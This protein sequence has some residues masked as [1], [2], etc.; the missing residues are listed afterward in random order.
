MATIGTILIQAANQA[1]GITGG[2]APSIAGMGGGTSSDDLKEQKRLTEYA[3]KNE[4]NNKQTPKFWT[5]AFKKMG[6]QMGLAGIL[7]QSQIFTSSVGAIFQIFG[8]FV[9]VILAPFVPM[10]I[11]AIRWLARQLKAAQATADGLS[12]VVKAVWN[13]FFGG[14]FKEN[15]KSLFTGLKDGIV[16]GVTGAFSGLINVVDNLWSHVE[17]FLS[18]VWEK[19]R[20]GLKKAWNSTLGGVRVPYIGWTIPTWGGGGGGTTTKTTTMPGS[21]NS[22]MG[23][24][25]STVTYDKDG[26]LIA[27]EDLTTIEGRFTPNPKVKAWL[28]TMGTEGP[29]IKSN[30]GDLDK[31]GREITGNGPDGADGSWWNKIFSKDTWSGAFGDLTTE[32]KKFFSGGLIQ[33]VLTAVGITVGGSVGVA[34]LGKGIGAFGNVMKAAMWSPKQLVNLLNAAAKTPGMMG[35]NT[36]K[37]AVRQLNLSKGAPSVVGTLR[38]LGLTEGATDLARRA[39]K[40][41][42]GGVGNATLEAW[43]RVTQPVADARRIASGA[44]NRVLRRTPVPMVPTVD[45]PNPRVPRISPNYTAGGDLA[46]QPGGRNPLPQGRGTSTVFSDDLAQAKGPSKLSRAVQA[47]NRWITKTGG[48]LKN[49]AGAGANAFKSVFDEGFS[50]ADDVVRIAAKTPGMGSIGQMVSFGFKRVIPGIAGAYMVGET[51]QDVWK[52]VKSD[53]PWLGDWKSLS[54]YKAEAMGAI[55]STSG[56]TGFGN[57]VGLLTGLFGKAQSAL[58]LGDSISEWQANIEKNRD[59]KGILSSGKLMD[60]IIRGT[61]GIGGAALSTF[62]PGLGTIAGMALYEGG[63]YATTGVNVPGM[64]QMGG[65]IDK[66]GPA[67]D[68]SDNLIKAIETGWSHGVNA[69]GIQ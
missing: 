40:T 19:I 44:A 43:Q 3:K 16:D 65:D 10:F 23:N 37:W 63:R 27:V 48:K 67:V 28:E 30:V 64:G 1:G 24:T 9:D 49:A 41:M 5:A 11:P 51:I 7:K 54:A 13:W 25:R 52:I 58:G 61:S 47:F 66:Y 6:I 55:F 17:S 68:F 18:L 35:L 32:F 29:K 8:A 20:G 38:G 2:G 39:L 50:L 14:K 26:K 34:A 21:E 56:I 57:P 59:E 31:E 46:A 33:D 15:I 53:A 22:P 12:K 36:A 69:L 60:A 4:D 45:V 62:F 42:G